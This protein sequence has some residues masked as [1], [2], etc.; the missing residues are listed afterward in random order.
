ME[1]RSAFLTISGLTKH[2]GDKLILDGIDLILCHNCIH[3][4][5]G[6]SGS[7]KTTL[8]NVISGLTSY[9]HGSILF[10]EKPAISYVFQEDRLLDW[11][12]VYK[13]I[14][15]VLKDILPPPV[16]REQIERYLSMLGLIDYAGYYPPQLSGGMRQRVSAIRAFLYPSNL[17]LMDEAFKSVD[18]NI[19]M[20][21]IDAVIDLWKDKPRTI[22]FVTHDVREALALSQRIHIFSEIPVRVIKEYEID[23]PVGGRNLADDYFLSLEGEIY[24]ILMSEHF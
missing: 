7:G 22:L 6:P 13:N 18:I 11:M 23:R 19:K 20:K 8:L 14:E 21:L 5:L 24:E 9:T 1:N 17:L 2:Y 3:T 10:S 4:I 12:T 15:I 16:R